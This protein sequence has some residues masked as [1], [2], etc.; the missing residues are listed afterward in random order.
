MEV[1]YSD[2]VNYFSNVS[3]KVMGVHHHTK[4]AG[5]SHSQ[6]S[7]PFPVFVFPLS[8]KAKFTFNGTPYIISPGTVVHGGADMSL[9]KVVLGKTRWEYIIVFYEAVTQEPDNMC[10]ADLHFELSAGSSPRLTELLWRLWRAYTHPDTLSLFRTEML[11]RCVLEELLVCAG[12]RHSGNAKELFD[13]VS[14]YIQEHYTDPLSVRE[15]AEQYG[16]TENR[17]FYIFNKYAGIGP[18]DYLTTYRLN[19]ARDLL[20]TGD[21]NVSEVAKSAGYP[22]PLYFSRMFRKRFGSSPSAIRE[23]YRQDQFSQPLCRTTG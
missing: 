23:R 11:F 22:D 15:L 12:G 14:L 9:D 7:A 8:G 19:R 10:M 17:L 6:M 4:G 13:Q 20:I 16:V 18:G 1:S 21:A 3:Y 2:L 5:C